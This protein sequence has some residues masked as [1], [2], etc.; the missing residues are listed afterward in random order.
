MSR[1]EDE[2]NWKKVPDEIPEIGVDVLVYY[3]SLNGNQGYFVIGRL[4][5]ISTT[6]RKEGE[7][8]SYEWIDSE[9]NAITPLYWCAVESPEAE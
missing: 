4:E 5:S 3:K 7:D 2:M 8:I 9:Y 6:K 1:I